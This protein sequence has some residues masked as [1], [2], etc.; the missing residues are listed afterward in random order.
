MHSHMTV[1]VEYRGRGLWAICWSG[2]GCWGT[3][4]EWDYERSP[5]NREDDWLETHRFELDFALSKAREL[6]KTLRVMKWT[7]QDIL[8]EIE[9]EKGPVTASQR[10]SEGLPGPDSIRYTPEDIQAVRSWLGAAFETI[11]GGVA[12][13]DP[14]VIWFHPSL[15]TTR[16]EH[17]ARRFK[18]W[19]RPGQWLVREQPY[20]EIGV[21]DDEVY[22]SRFG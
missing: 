4:G 22:Q 6:A 11:R 14:L 10:D 5:S 7:V 12:E 20:G 19:V 17:H 15:D 3:D 16:P 21:Y 2:R 9:R 13:N 1:T 8:D 18:A